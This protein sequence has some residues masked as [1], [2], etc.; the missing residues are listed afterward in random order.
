MEA[1]AWESV[2]EVLVAAA[3]E[4]A[5]VDPASASIPTDRTATGIIRGPPKDTIGKRRAPGEEAVP[6]AT[7]IPVARGTSETTS[8]RSWWRKGITLN[9]N[10]RRPA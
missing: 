6:P 4:A 3:T 7:N 2:A 9:G 8:R 5:V 1:E 10:L